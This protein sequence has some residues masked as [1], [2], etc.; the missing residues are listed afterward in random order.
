MSKAKV[1]FDTVREIGLALPDVE[2]ATIYRLPALKVR[3]KLLAC[4]AVHKSAEPGSLAVRMD[5]DQR[6]GCW[7]RSR[8]HTT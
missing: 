5:F 7:Q 1:T 2:E 8:E 6:A 3:G 4:L